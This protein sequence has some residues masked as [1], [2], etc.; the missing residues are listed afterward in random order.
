[1]CG[2]F[3]LTESDP[4]VVAARFRVSPDSLFSEG[5][6]RYNAAPGQEILTVSPEGDGRST[7]SLARWGLVPGWADDLKT[8]YRM[9]NARAEGLETSRAYG[10]LF[11]KAEGRC[12][13]PADGFYEWLDPARSGGPKRPV[14]FTVDEGQLFGLAGLV[15]E[16]EWE[17]GTL[18]S[19]TI[20]TTEADEA[21]AP[22]HDRMPVILTD[23]AAEEAWLDEDT[24]TGALADLLR[25]LDSDRVSSRLANPALNRVGAVPEGPELLDV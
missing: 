15:T 10:P 9:I 3:T 20:I 14:R 2:R 19:C 22:V 23:P 25:P 7:C 12:V 24:E 16:R 5:L 4:G 13:I 17:G 11:R 8:G 18:R 1:M 21:V 6:G